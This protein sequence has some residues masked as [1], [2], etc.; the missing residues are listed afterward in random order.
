MRLNL[1]VKNIL[2]GSA[3]FFSLTLFGQTYSKGESVLS[4]LGG[5]FIGTSYST[6]FTLGELAVSQLDLSV[7]NTLTQGFH[8]AK[9]LY[10]N[11]SVKSKN[12][13]KLLAYPNPVLSDVNISVKGAEFAPLLLK[14]YTLSG[15]L[16]KQS[17]MLER[18][19]TLDLA[20]YAK[21]TYFVHAINMQTSKRVRTIKLQKL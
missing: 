11:N 9:G 6:D 15:K 20:D 21:G 2:M 17:I 18:S 12:S 16:I 10:V 8:Q 13:F 19:I 3:L 7:D 14:M 4:S 5:S 1:F